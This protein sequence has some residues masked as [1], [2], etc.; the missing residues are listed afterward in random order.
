MPVSYHDILGYLNFSSG[1]PDPRFLRHLNDLYRELEPD[2][3]EQPDTLR[4]AYDR[5]RAELGTLRQ[6]S[7]AFAESSQAEAVLAIVF[8]HFPPAYR[9]HHRDLLF[10]QPDA[11]LWR[12]LFVGRVCERVLQRGSPW[13]ETER[14]VDDALAQ[15]NDTLGYR[16]LAVLHTAQEMKPYDHEWFRPLP[17]FVRG[18]AVAA[19]RYE[20]VV[21]LALQALER[22]DAAVLRAAMFDPA[23]LEELALDVRAYDFDHPA[24]RRPN[25][26]FGWWDALQIDQ[27]G[28]YRRFV[29]TQVTLDALLARVAAAGELPADELLVEASAVLAG[30]MLMASGTSG[31]GPDAH[32]SSVTLTNL[33]PRIAAYRDQFYDQFLGRLAGPHADRL[34]AEAAALK[35]PLAGARQHLN[36]AL[37]RIRAQQ[38]EHTRL[39]VLFARL[40][41]APTALRLAQVV[42]AASARMHCEIQCRIVAAHRALDQHDLDEAARLVDEVDDVLQRGIHCGALADPWNI[43]GFQGQYSL[44]PAPENSIPDHRLDELIE[45]VA[46]QFSL[47]ARVWSEAAARSDPARQD[48][49]ASLVRRLARWWDQFAS[50]SVGGVSG[51]SGREEAESAER[52]AAALSAWQA[53]GAA[54]ADVGFWRRHV[55]QFDSPKAYSLVLEALLAKGD[56]VA[57]MALVIQWLSR[58]GDVPLRSGDHSFHLLA[59]RW[60]DLALAAEPSGQPDAERR[61]LVVKFFDFLEANAE[62]YGAVPELSLGEAGS[63]RAASGQRETDEAVEE[64]RELFAAA[65]EDL[66]YRDTTDDGIEGE[67]LESGTPPSDFELEIEARR[68]R[69]RLILLNTLASLWKRVAAAAI[70][71]PAPPPVDAAHL[72]AWIRDAQVNHRGLIGLAD[73]VAGQRVPAPTLSRESLIEFDRRQRVKEHLLETILGAAVDTAHSLAFLHAALPDSAVDPHDRP[74]DRAALRLLTWAIRGDTAS[75]QAHWAEALEELGSEPLL[76]VPLGKGGSPQAVAAARRLQHALRELAVWLPRRGLFSQ[77]C[78]LLELARVMEARHSVGGGAVTEFDRLFETAF[79]ALVESLVDLADQWQSAPA[80]ELAGESPT[81]LLLECLEQ[82]TESLQQQWLAHSRSLRISVLERVADDRAWKKL[83]QFIEHY[84]RELFTQR[85]LNFGNLRAILHQGVDT[86]L[87]RISQEEDQQEETARLL[88]D[89]D[90]SLPR[91]EAVKHL[92]LVLEAIVENYAEYRDYNTTT[93]QS[94][95]GELLYTLLDFLRLRVQYDRVAWNLRPIQ[96]AHDVLLRRGASEAAGLWRQAFAERTA[97]VAARELQRLGLLIKKYGMR[98][99]TIAD[100]L[101]ERFVRPLAV[102]VV[103]S[104]IAPAAEELRRGAPGT[105]FAELVERAEELVQQPTG[106]GLDVPAWIE[107][108]EEEIDAATRAASAPGQAQHPAKGLPQAP[109]GVAEVLQQLAGWEREA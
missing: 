46:R 67:M 65:Y 75:L 105:T 51:F 26:Q 97:D 107:S 72:A 45:L 99:P 21:S 87:S 58:A 18:A 49:I 86:W 1:A 63:A 30:T 25:Y 16:P 61:A 15:L 73:E 96:W 77:T 103:R 106:A 55:G 76:Y 7:P 101:A 29:V 24:N 60:L 8:E 56:L 100:R 17:L 44:F 85:F 108:L 64:D 4:R 22:T 9:R 66:V 53:A 33:L 48:Q 79:R 57:A 43:L 102:D 59:V 35:Q 109:L 104:L 89:L 11:A 36:Q 38:L 90:Q 54:S 94:D 42:P 3:Q 5:L 92:S 80:A 91:A 39:A 23:A 98:L 40:G 41:H 71:G 83:C 78:Q 95:R 19:G 62:E 69:D 6:S 68:L 37:A 31:S 32:D 13:D 20:A 52:V 12:P 27:R 74:A 81:N 84:G 82:L 47:A 70:V 93:T 10:H 88:A 2:G 50:T 34:R 14:I 28:H